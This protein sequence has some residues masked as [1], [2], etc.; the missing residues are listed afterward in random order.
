MRGEPADPSSCPD[1]PSEVAAR[2]RQQM[3][4]LKRWFQWELWLLEPR[5]FAPPEETPEEPPQEDKPRSN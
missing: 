5:S 2:L 4:R 3:T 1:D